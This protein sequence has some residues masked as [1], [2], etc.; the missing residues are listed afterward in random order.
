VLGVFGGLGGE[1]PSVAIMDDK[2]YSLTIF[3][4]HLE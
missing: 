2:A 1:L 4:K 3:G